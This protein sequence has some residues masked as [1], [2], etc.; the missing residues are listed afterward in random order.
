M[1][2]ALFMVKPSGREPDRTEKTTGNP[3]E[4][5]TLAASDSENAVP[6][7]YPCS[8]GEAKTTVSA[9]SPKP[10]SSPPVSS[11]RMVHP[12]SARFWVLS[13]LRLATTHC[14][15]G[16]NRMA[17]AP[18]EVTFRPTTVAARRLSSSSTP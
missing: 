8:P 7:E 13:A 12:A 10:V 2:P 1:T 6:T 14:M 4:L 5:V 3:V 15:T 11:R 18:A 9:S 16:R 17:T